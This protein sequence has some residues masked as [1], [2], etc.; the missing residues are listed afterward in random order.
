LTSI[1]VVRPQ[2]N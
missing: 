2:L 1:M